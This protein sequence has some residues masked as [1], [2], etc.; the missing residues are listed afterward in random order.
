MQRIYFIDLT[1]IKMNNFAGFGLIFVSKDGKKQFDV[2]NYSLGDLQNRKIIVED[3]EK[4][5]TTKEGDGRYVVKFRFAENEGGDMS[6]GKYFTNSEE[7]KQMLDKIEE[8][9]GFPFQTI[10]KR[11]V[12]EKEKLN[13]HLLKI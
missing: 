11:Q 3:F 8:I 10:I 13:T 7:M 1:G 9:K 4:G 5:I 2:V 12:L 6:E